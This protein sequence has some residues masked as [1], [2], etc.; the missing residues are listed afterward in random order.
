M[1]LDTVRMSQGE[2][3]VGELMLLEFGDKLLVLLVGELAGVVFKDG[4]GSLATGRVEE[5]YCGDIISV[6]FG[7]AGYL[8]SQDPHGDAVVP[9]AEP[10]ID[11][12]PRGPLTSFDAAQSSSMNRVLVP[13]KKKLATRSQSSIS[14][15][16]HT[17]TK[18]CGS[19]S[20]KPL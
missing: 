7:D 20:T 18:M 2:D 10:E 5:H 13:E 12:L 19:R 1:V 16:R 17:I 11:Q 14:C 15:C 4:L 9:G 6:W 3:Q 8:L